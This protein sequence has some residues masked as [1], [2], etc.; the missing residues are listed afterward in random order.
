MATAALAI[1]VAACADVLLPDVGALAPVAPIDASADAR[2]PDSADGAEIDAGPRVRSVV[3]AGGDVACALSPTGALKCW[4]GGTGAPIAVASGMSFVDVAIGPSHA[5]YP[6]P[7]FPPV[8]PEVTSVCAIRAGDRALLCWDAASPTPVVVDDAH[9][10]VQASIAP[11]RVCALDTSGTVRCWG[12]IGAAA[13]GVKPVVAAGGGW[14]YV[15]GGERRICAIGP[16]DELACWEAFLDLG[17]IVLPP[18]AIAKGTKWREVRTTSIE[19]GILGLRA[20]GALLTFD[21]T[22]GP[23]PDGSPQIGTI[24]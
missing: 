1:A 22:R 20:D 23:G 5:N 12:A 7:S 11:D 19:G 10:F 24:G 18:V 16:D 3:F 2:T 14:K 15:A 4:G 9:A 17:V 13:A 21:E 6:E 8:T